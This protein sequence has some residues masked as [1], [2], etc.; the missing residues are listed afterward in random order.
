MT[1]RARNVVLVHCEEKGARSQGMCVCVFATLAAQGDWMYKVM[2][3]VSFKPD[4]TCNHPNC[5][6]ES[7][8]NTDKLAGKVPKMYA[9]YH[10][11]GLKYETLITHVTSRD[12]FLTTYFPYGCRE[13]PTVYEVLLLP[14]QPHSCRADPSTIINQQLM[15]VSLLS[16]ALMFRE[17]S[18]ICL[19]K[20]LQSLS[21]STLL[22]SISQMCA[23]LAAFKSSQESAM[24]Q[25]QCCK[26]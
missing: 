5:L 22:T 16:T 2:R 24:S 23:T 21:A 13:Y 9:I 12:L 7:H 4:P 18:R 6:S 15:A 11:N 17:V 3:R 20:K 25:M 19:C 26:C 1:S 14:K 8:D 10:D